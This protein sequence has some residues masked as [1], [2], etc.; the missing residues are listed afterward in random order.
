MGITNIDAASPDMVEGYLSGDV[1]MIT[2][3]LPRAM[4]RVI[5]IERMRVDAVKK[6]ISEAWTQLPRCKSSECVLVATHTRFDAAGDPWPS[7][8]EHATVGGINGSDAPV[9]RP[10]VTRLRDALSILEAPID[11]TELENQFM[12]NTD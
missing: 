7:C 1:A 4:A 10:Y 3:T 5:R 2:P 11:Y 12:T 6:L 8:V 9:A